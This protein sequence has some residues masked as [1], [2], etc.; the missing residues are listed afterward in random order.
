VTQFAQPGDGI[1]APHPRHPQVHEDDIDLELLGL[2]YGFGTIAGFA[3]DLEV[4]IVGEYAAQ[5]VPH[6]RVVVDDQ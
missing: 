4:G 6:D 1:D 5:P 2:P 3:D